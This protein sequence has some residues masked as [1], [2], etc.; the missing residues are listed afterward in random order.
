MFQS[1]KAVNQPI[2]KIQAWKI[3]REAAITNEITG[4]LATH[5]MRKTFANR[6]YHQLNHDLVKTQ[7]AMGHKNIISTLA[8]LSFVDDEIDQPILAS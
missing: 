6:V 8:Y 4:K 3:L 7:R 1:R 2:G 5:M